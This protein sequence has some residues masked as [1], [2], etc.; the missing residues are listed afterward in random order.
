MLYN[1]AVPASD[2]N[3][4]TSAR[5]ILTTTGSAEEARTIASALI[6]SR[7][8]ACANIVGPVESHYWWKERVE[9]TTEHLLL[10][11]T[12]APAVEKVREKI[13]ALH[14]YE[15]PEL[16]VLNIESGD[17]NYLKWLVGSVSN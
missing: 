3:C 6:E 1:S 4:M 16:V 5:L 15:M 14:S 9:T 7:L 12:T 2:A 11:K 17:Q 10:I 8:A 13:R